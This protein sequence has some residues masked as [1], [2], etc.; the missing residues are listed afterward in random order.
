MLIETVFGVS[1]SL[2]YI[3]FFFLIVSGQT[4]IKS[5]RSTGSIASPSCV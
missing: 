5:M 2:N 3:F 4:E 1:L